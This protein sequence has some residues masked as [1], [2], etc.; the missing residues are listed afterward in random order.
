MREPA[1]KFP[2]PSLEEREE[3]KRLAYQRARPEM[4]SHG[5]RN[6]AVIEHTLFGSSPFIGEENYLSRVP[7]LIEASRG[8][9]QEEQRVLL[10]PIRIQEEGLAQLKFV[11]KAR[12][13]SWENRDTTGISIVEDSTNIY[14]EPSPIDNATGMIRPQWKLVALNDEGKEITDGGVWQNVVV[15]PDM[16]GWFTIRE[17]PNSNSRLLVAHLDASN[18]ESPKAA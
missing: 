11:E 13:A 5:G 15:L 4:P 6:L 18:I 10:T 12:G 17:V 8:G 1:G 14:V 16:Q 9:D 3:R 7:S 2:M